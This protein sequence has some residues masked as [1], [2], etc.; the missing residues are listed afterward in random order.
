MYTTLNRA[1]MTA[2]QRGAE[3]TRR[4][5]EV[6]G[7]SDLKVLATALAEIAADEAQHNVDFG[8][9]IRHAYREIELLPTQNRSSRKIASKPKL[10]PI[11]APGVVDIDPHGDLNPFSLVQ[12]YGA[13]QLRAALTEYSLSRLKEASAIVE[14]RNPSTK[15]KN[16][17][18]K[19]TIIDYIVEHV[20]GPGY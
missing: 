15:P 13:N 19:D 3:A 9:R 6:L 16:K 1:T 8:D 12:L 20:A 7:L 14:Q 4:L 18:R 17:S 10:I 11:A 5:R 2:Q